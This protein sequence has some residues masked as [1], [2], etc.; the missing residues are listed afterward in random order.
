[1]HTRNAFPKSFRCYTPINHKVYGTI[2]ITPSNT[3]LIVKGAKTGK[4]SFPK[5]HKKFTG[6][7]TESYI[8]CAVRETLEETGVDL[9]SRTHIAVHKLSIGEYYFFEIEEELPLSVQDCVEV[10]DAQWV[11]VE[12][13]MRLPC[14]VDVNNFLSRLQRHMRS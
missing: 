1:M 7:T 12:E 14:N 5:G 3:I 13:M 6:G 10:A 4:W 11:S 8:D 9:A 2:C